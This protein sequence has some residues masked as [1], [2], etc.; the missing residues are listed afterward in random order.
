[1]TSYMPNPGG[2]LPP[3]QIIGRDQDIRRFW[4]ILSRQ[5]LLLVGPRRVGKSCV[6][7]KMR[8][9]PPAG[10]E[11]LLETV[12]DCDAIA[13]FLQRLLGS[14]ASVLSWKG[15]VAGRTLQALQ[16]VGGSV[17]LGAQGEAGSLKAA[18]TVRS[19]HWQLVLDALL[20]DLQAHAARRGARLVLAWDEFTWFLHRMTAA[21]QGAEAGLL[22]DALRRVRQSRERYPDLRFVFTGSIGM[23]EV[24][25]RLKAEGAIQ[26]PL[27]DVD[28][29]VLFVLDEHDARALAFRLTEEAP[30]AERAAM[31]EALAGLGEGHPF[32]MQHLARALREAGTWTVGAARAALGELLEHSQ[33][34]LDLGQFVQRIDLYQGAE[35]ARRTR[36]LLDALV[37]GP[38]RPAELAT[39]IGVDREEVL[40]IVDF[41]HRNLYVSRRQGRADFQLALIRRYW[42]IERDLLDQLPA[43]LR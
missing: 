36:A 35:R 5:S 37:P 24:L 34:P 11:M 26:S 1:M 30:E 42:A 2:I 16:L 18:L 19:Q 20:D 29:Q 28:T 31:I 13:A 23:Q 25:D 32:V 40:E 14:A 4:D 15:K 12:E 8:H 43:E 3:P 21:G 10:V 38:A 39:R 27:N 22:L 41:L 33:D 17:E 7:Q 9:A 6:L